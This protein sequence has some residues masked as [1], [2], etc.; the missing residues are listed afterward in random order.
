MYKHA[1]EC[2]VYIYKAPG[3]VKQLSLMLL[4]KICFGYS[5]FRVVI[6]YFFE[7]YLVEFPLF[8]I[9]S[10][11]MV[12]CCLTATRR[13][14]GNPEGLYWIWNCNLWP[15]CLQLAF[16]LLFNWMS[17]IAPGV[18]SLYSI[19]GSEQL[20]HFSYSHALINIVCICKFDEFPSCINGHI[21]TRDNL[22]TFDEFLLPF[23]AV[24]SAW[25]QHT[26]FIH[27][28]NW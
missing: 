3:I 20:I 22:F 17:Y 11:W 4:S 7:E 12:A 16:W 10:G 1:T 14:A 28:M 27:A 13:V 2:L 24:L 23:D 19:I 18:E 6:M 5:S 21:K 25:S 9:I 15:R 26:M 8:P